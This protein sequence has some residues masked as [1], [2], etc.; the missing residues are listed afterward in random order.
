VSPI[1][2]EELEKKKNKNM[3]ENVRSGDKRKAQDKGGSHCTLGKFSCGGGGGSVFFCIYFFR[4][5][6]FILP[7]TA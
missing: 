4:E 5:F 1:V 2:K 6:A 3:K 7:A